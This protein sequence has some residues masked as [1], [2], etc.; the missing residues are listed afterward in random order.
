MIHPAR[1]IPFDEL[2]NK[3]Q[4]AVSFGQVYEHVGVEGLRLYCYSDATVYERKW[5]D[6]TIMARGL[7]LDVDKK[8]VVAT[9]FPK[10]FNVGE[11]Q[12]S[13]DIESYDPQNPALPNIMPR[14]TSFALI[15]DLPFETFEK[16]DGS[17]IIIFHHNGKWKCATKGS[18]S[19]DQAKWAQAIVDDLFSAD[20]GTTYLAEG[21]YPSNRIV[22]DYKG[23]TRLSILAAY[24]KDGTEMSYEEL[25]KEYVFTGKYELVP[26]HEYNHLSEL[27]E[28][29]K[30]LSGNEE[31]WVIRFSDGTRLKIKGDEY[32]RIHRMVSNLTPLAIW[33]EMLE[34]REGWQD[35]IRKSLPDEFL[36]DFDLLITI[37]TEKVQTLVTEISVICDKLS[38]LTDKQIGLQLNNLPEDIRRFIFPYRKGNILE[39]RG[40]RLLFDAVRP[41]RNI[42]EGYRASSSV[43][44]V[45][46]AK[47]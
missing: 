16:L 9:P 42:L 45:Q 29:A 13:I 31:G 37:L 39:G 35:E 38:G 24:R 28:K 33:R 46:E 32:C 47:E 17:L 10:F 3:L 40:R 7:I 41:D 1:K 4:E 36:G 2:Y 23:A 26:R 11:C 43:A 27:L 22:V 14:T 15:P 21:I 30:T 19:S 25:K 20:I 5:N 12:T 8:E 34:N 6:V 18:L 44:R